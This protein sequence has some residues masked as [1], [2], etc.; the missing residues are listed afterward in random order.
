[1][2]QNFIYIKSP[3]INRITKNIFLGNWSSSVNSNVLIR[4]NIKYIIGLNSRYKIQS[5]IDLYKKMNIKYLHINLCDNM[6]A[7]IFRIFPLTNRFICEALNKNKNI[8]IH[9]TMGISRAATIVIAFLLWT[10]YINDKNSDKLRS[11]YHKHTRLREIFEYVKMQRKQIDP[12]LNFIK[13]LQLYE[14]NLI[15]HTINKLLN[16]FSD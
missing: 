5:D 3:N 1:M 16:N 7:N 15:C 4:Y 8:L 14:S 9:C 10:Y 6:K 2:N 12:N 11:I 13:Q